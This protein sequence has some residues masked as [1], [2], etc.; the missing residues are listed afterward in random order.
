MNS[1]YGSISSAV[2]DPLSDELA[3]KLECPDYSLEKPVEPLLERIFDRRIKD[4]EDKPKIKAPGSESGAGSRRKTQEEEEK[5]G[6]IKKIG[7]I[8]K[9]KK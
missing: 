2:F 8:F 3:A 7:D 9:K 5:K 4:R 6:L 1:S